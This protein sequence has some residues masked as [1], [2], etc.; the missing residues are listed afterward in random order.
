LLHQGLSVSTIVA[1]NAVLLCLS[2]LVTS[3]E[4]QE[5]Q[6]TW[7]SAV[8]SVLVIE[9]D[10]IWIGKGEEA[11]FK[12]QIVPRKGVLQIAIGGEFAIEIPYRL[13]GDKLILTIDGSQIEYERKPVTGR[14]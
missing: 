2:L 13:K 1:M 7:T 8:G 12:G 10:E 4:V 3:K 9:D 6:G 14:G 11:E 5:L